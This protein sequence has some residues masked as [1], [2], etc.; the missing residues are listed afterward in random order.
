[1]ET[2]KG[3]QTKQRIVSEAAVLLNQRGFEGLSYSDLMAS[4][5]LRKGGIYRHFASKEDLVAAAFEYAW[6]GAIGQRL[7]NLELIENSVDRLKQFVANF[8]QSRPSLPG[9]CPLMNAAIDS[10][11]GNPRLRDSASRALQSWLAHL[12]REI[13]RGQRRGEIRKKVPAQSIATLLVSTLEGAL[14]ISRLQNDPKAL[15]DAK[16]HL[17]SFLD[18]DIRTAV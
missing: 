10:D 18:S 6:K 15:L 1:M 17:W 2:K 16:A 5:G 8:V 3:E 12:R 4:T 9:G 7:D 13:K 14:M 11:D